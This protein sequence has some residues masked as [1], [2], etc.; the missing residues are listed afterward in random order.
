MD[1][2]GCIDIGKAAAENGFAVSSGLYQAGALSCDAL[3][4]E[5]SIF[6]FSFVRAGLV[7]AGSSAGAS[8]AA[9]AATDVTWLSSVGTSASASGELAPASVSWALLESA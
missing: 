2:G 5:V 7:V 8:V 6:P 4:V 1:G 3:S 9:P